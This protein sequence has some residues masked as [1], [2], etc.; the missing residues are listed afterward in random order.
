M[1]LNKY[2]I[3]KEVTDFYTEKCLIYYIEVE[4]CPVQKF[5]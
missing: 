3:I 4:G 1:G 5:A 2:Q